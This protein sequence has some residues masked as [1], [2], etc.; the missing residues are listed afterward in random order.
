MAESAKQKKFNKEANVKHVKTRTVYKPVEQYERKFKRRYG[1][2]L[3]SAVNQYLKTARN[4]LN[5]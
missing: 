3:G 4:Q 5:V 1:A 2:E